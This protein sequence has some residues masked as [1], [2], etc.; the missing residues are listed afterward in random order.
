RCTSRENVMDIREQL[1][2]SAVAG[3]LPQTRRSRAQAAE[4]AF[5]D[6]QSR[7]HSGSVK[8]SV[9]GRTVQISRVEHHDAPDGGY[10]DV[11]LAGNAA[12]P[13]YR[14]YNPPLLVED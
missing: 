14:I 3:D 9:R 6:R 13:H 4:Q 5:R 7:D 8:V 2:Q 10:A 11:W 1:R 12:E